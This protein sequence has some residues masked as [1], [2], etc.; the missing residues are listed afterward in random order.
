MFGTTKTANGEENML[1]L[2][3]RKLVA[4]PCAAS[5]SVICAR[6]VLE[7]SIAGMNQPLR[8]RDL[9]GGGGGRGGGASRVSTS[10]GTDDDSGAGTASGCT[11]S[12][13]SESSNDS[14][15]SC[16]SVTLIRAPP[17]FETVRERQRKW[18]NKERLSGRGQT[19]G[20]RRIPPTQHQQGGGGVAG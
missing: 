2:R 10:A 13:N 1:T 16:S 8:A 17:D 9:G 4:C 11:L 20:K 18:G 14:P 5:P 19:N 6:C 7:Q 12:T 3:T 15:S